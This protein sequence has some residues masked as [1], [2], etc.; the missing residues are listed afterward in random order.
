MVLGCG[1]TLRAIDAFWVEA[2]A[3]PFKAGR[4]IWE[5][6]LEVF[7][8]VRQHVRL[9]VVVCHVGTYCQVK[10]Y[11]MAVPTVKG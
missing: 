5:L 7:Q 6:F 11:Q 2:I 3:K 9:A 1:F 4:I 8:R 10:T